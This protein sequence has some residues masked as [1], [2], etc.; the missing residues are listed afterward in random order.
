MSEEDLD[1]EEKDVDVDPRKQDF[2]EWTTESAAI[3]SS[4]KAESPFTDSLETF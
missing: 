3:T 1:D 2:D 4:I